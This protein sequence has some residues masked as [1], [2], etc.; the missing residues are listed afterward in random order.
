MNNIIQEDVGRVLQD[1]FADLEDDIGLGDLSLSAE[2][3]L[4]DLGLES[5]SLVYLISELQQH[6]DLGDRL[7]RKMR[8]HQ[9]LLKDMRV[10][11]IQDMVVALVSTDAT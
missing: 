4:I 9:L 10:G 5:I 6:Y 1:I 2:T 7:F 11:E 8:E 3:R